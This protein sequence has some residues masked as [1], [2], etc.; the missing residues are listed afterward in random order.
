MTVHLYN[1]IILLHFIYLDILNY[2]LEH[3][4]KLGDIMAARYSKVA[5]VDTMWLLAVLSSESE[6]HDHII[7][8]IPTI[9]SYLFEAI[10]KENETIAK[11]RVK[12]FST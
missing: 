5:D 12:K 8:C 10:N 2:R 9:S 3:I 7:K 1:Y 4:I 6:C 11:V